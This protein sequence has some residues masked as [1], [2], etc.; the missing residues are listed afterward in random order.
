MKN[1]DFLSFT[2]YVVH[3]GDE[4]CTQKCLTRYLHSTTLSQRQGALRATLSILYI[5]SNKD[6]QI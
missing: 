1:C 2:L 3:L 5:M 6:D 4:P